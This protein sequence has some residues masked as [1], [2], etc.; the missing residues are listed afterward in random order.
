[1]KSIRPQNT[2]FRVVYTTHSYEEA[3]IIAGRLDH[4][5]IQSAIQ[6]ESAAGA[7]GITYGKIGEVNVIVRAEDYEIAHQILFPD[8]PPELDEN[9]H[10]IDFHSGEDDE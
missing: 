8:T 6:R 2:D 5:G 9:N 1:M 10:E 7:L 4:E 3:H